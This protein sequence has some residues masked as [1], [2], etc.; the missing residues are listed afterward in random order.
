M[1]DRPHISRCIPS[2]TPITAEEVSE[3]PALIHR[4]AIGIVHAIEGRDARKRRRLL[5]RHPPLQHAEIG[6]AD[7]ADFAVRPGLMSEPFDDVIEVLLLVAVEQ[8]KLTA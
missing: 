3:Y 7:A 6:L 2:H 5:D 4:S 1:A 8:P